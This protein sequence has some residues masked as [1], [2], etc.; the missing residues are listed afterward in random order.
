M[1]GRDIEPRESCQSFS[2]IGSLKCAWIPMNQINRLRIFS[3]PKLRS[4]SEFLS[5]QGIT[6]A[7]NLLYGF[8][9]V[10]ILPLTEYAKFAVV[11]GFSGTLNILMDVNFSGTLAPLIGTHVDDRTLIADYVASL[12]HLAYRLYVVVGVGAIFVYPIMVRHQSWDW[13]TVSAMVAILLAVSWLVRLSGSYGAV[14]IVCRY[15]APWYRAQLIASLGTLALLL[16]FW[17]IHCLSAFAAILINVAGMA[18]VSFSNYFYAQKV[19]ACKGNSTREKRNAIIHL[20]MPNMP[21]AIFY[22]FQGQ[23]ALLLITIFGHT[24]AVAGVGALS[25]LSQIFLFFGQMNF[26]L[27]EPYFARLPES[28]FKRNYAAAVIVE[29]ILCLVVSGTALTFPQI[30]LWILGHKYNGLSR[31]VFLAIAGS[32]LSYFSGV[33]WGLHSA[34]KFVYWWASSAYIFLTIAVQVWFICRIDLSTVRAVLEL[35]I[36]TACVSVLMNALAGVYGMIYGPRTAHC[37]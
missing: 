9:C 2:A 6:I 25:R 34:R 31:E 14:L 16:T 1:F 30:F 7:A 22:A 13:W 28:K 21:N 27:L 20:A 3:A 33:L 29:I 8:L 23:I 11:F 35:N 17:S 10:R 24:S 18:F 32:S 15:R 12:R 19:L 5:L 26:L 4:I 36:V 37:V